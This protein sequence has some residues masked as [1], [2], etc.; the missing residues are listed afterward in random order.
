M[1]NTGVYTFMCWTYQKSGA[2]SDYTY[3]W[4]IYSAS[5]LSEHEQV[6]TWV[7]ATSLSP[8]GIALCV[9]RMMSQS[10]NW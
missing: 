7:T 5:I 3:F 8:A 1:K 6:G 9:T 10:S 2:Q 4:D